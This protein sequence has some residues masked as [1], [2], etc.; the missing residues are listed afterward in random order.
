MGT[1][2][3]CTGLAVRPRDDTA[4][5]DDLIIHVLTA[6]GKLLNQLEL[7]LFHAWR[8]QN[9]KGCLLA[10]DT[11]LEARDTAAINMGSGETLE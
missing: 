10:A 11:P 4:G 6:C 9:R 3:R 1:K 8:L 5:R 2:V 7:P